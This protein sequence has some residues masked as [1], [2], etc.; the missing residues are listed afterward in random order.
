M[1]NYLTKNMI[2]DLASRLGPRM[3]LGLEDVHSLLHFYISVKILIRNFLDYTQKN[4]KYS[5]F[6]QLEQDNK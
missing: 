6:T 2:I 5:Q 4:D 3:R 1:Y